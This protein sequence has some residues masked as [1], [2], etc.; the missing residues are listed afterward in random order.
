MV[1]LNGACQHKSP[2]ILSQDW[3][4]PFHATLCPGF[5]RISAGKVSARCST[6][7]LKLMCFHHWSRLEKEFP[8]LIGAPTKRNHGVHQKTN[9]A[10]SRYKITK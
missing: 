2:I 8:G 5:I 4:H 9:I 7:F 1:V 3:V 10:G 6:A